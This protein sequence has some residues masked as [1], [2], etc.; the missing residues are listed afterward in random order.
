MKKKIL[1]TGATGNV[2]K[3][4]CDSLSGLGYDVLTSSRSKPE[5]WD[6]PFTAFDI[7]DIEDFT[8]SLKGVSVLK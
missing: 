5:G 7:T 8:E 1:I 6:Y 2:G 3:S 4:L